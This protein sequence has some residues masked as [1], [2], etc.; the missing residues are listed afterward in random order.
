MRL[1]N[2][3]LI[4][5]KNYSELNVS[6]SPQ[7]NCFVGE[8][9]SGKTNLL[10]AIYYLS[11]SKS[12]F[13]TVD[14]QNIKHGAPYFMIKGHFKVRENKYEIQCVQKAG[15]KKILKNNKTPYD[16][17]SEHI[18]QFPVVLIAPDDTDLIRDSSEA[19]RRFLDSIISQLDSTYLNNLIRYNHFIKQRNS[20]LKLFATKNYVDYDLLEPYDVNL[21]SIGKELYKIRNSFIDRFIP[22]FS[23]HYLNLSEGK[24]KTSIVYESD[25]NEAHWEENFLQ[26]RKKDLILQR[27]T[28]GIHKDDLNFQVEGY[29]L[30]KYGSQGQQKSFLI[31][32]K[33]AHYD[34]IKSEKKINPLLLLDDIF[35]K[36]DDQRISKLLEMISCGRFGQLFVTDARPE[37]T[38][39]IFSSIQSEVKFFQ[40]SQGEASDIIKD[41]K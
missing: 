38:I 41:N 21:I 11:I 30:K 10:D 23:S 28:M 1:E 37:R 29:P 15:Q 16:K 6:F 13:N 7:I 9:G 17:L 22:I 40:I 36:L 5:F 12:A 35:D 24:E 33:L 31:A 3:S 26:A 8:N 20:L 18:G 14:Q 25:L 4:N 34:L 19:R 2:I 27:T 32:L 39:K